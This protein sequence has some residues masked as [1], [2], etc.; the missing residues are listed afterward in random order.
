MVMLSTLAVVAPA[1]GA[2]L[3]LTQSA[4]AR[5]QQSDARCGSADT[6]DYQAE[7]KYS[8]TLDNPEYRRIP[9]PKAPRLALWSSLA[10]VL[11]ASAGHLAHVFGTLELAG[12]L[13]NLYVVS[14]FTGP[15]AAIAIDSAVFTFS[16]ATGYMARRRQDAG[17]LWLGLVL[18]TVVSAVCNLDYAVH[19]VTGQPVVW[20][21]ITSLDQWVALK[22]LALAAVLPFLAIV[23][24]RILEAAGDSDPDSAEAENSTDAETWPDG[25]LRIDDRESR[26]VHAVAGNGQGRRGYGA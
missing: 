1:A 26:P 7:R 16:W 17:L 4:R 15:I 8:M 25:S 18:C 22:V 14:V 6:I 11:L 19:V 3:L 9:L 21:S 20:K 24:G 12:P 10:L 13:A 23:F 2:L 5:Q